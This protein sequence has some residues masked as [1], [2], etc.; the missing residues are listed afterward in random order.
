MGQDH[1]TNRK[2]ETQ[3]QSRKEGHLTGQIR[4][5][6]EDLQG[7]AQPEQTALHRTEFTL[8]WSWSVKISLYY[9]NHHLEQSRINAQ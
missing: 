4:E 1:K 3:G 9:G 2:D 5:E 6:N 8:T 7:A